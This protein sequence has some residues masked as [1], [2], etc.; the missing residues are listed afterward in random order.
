MNLWPFAM[1]H[2]VWVWNRL[3]KKENG[4]IPQELFSKVKSTHHD[5]KRTHV[6]GCPTYVLDPRL[7]DGH[8]IPKWEPRARRGQFL[9]F[10]KRHSSTVGLIRNITTG[11]V[12]PQYHVVYDDLFQTLRNPDAGGVGSR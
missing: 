8:K 12:T 11:S 3:P 2:A 10:S 1:D 7:Q 5:L 4:L 9:G 6:W